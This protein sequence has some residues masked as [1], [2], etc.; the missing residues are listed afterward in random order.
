MSISNSYPVP[1]QILSKYRCLSKNCLLC[2]TKYLTGTGVYPRIASC[3]EPKPPQVQGSIRKIPPVP[4]FHPQHPKRRAEVLSYQRI[5][6]MP[7]FP[8][9]SPSLLPCR[10]QI[11]P[12]PRRPVPNSSISWSRTNYAF[13]HDLKKADT[14]FPASAHFS[15]MYSPMKYIARNNPPA[16]SS[17]LPAPSAFPSPESPVSDCRSRY[18]HGLT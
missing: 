13:P 12:P 7:I 2:R 16:S 15:F 17:K 9:S 18:C 6:Y 10:Y 11:P 8:A 14:V 5:R 3:A 4:N 1:N